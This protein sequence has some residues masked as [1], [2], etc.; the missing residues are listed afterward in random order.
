MVTFY[1]LFINIVLSLLKYGIIKKYICYFISK[2]VGC[3][4]NCMRFIKL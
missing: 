1:K 3:D 4:C 2:L